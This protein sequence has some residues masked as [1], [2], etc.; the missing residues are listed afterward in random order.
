[1]NCRAVQR[2]L[3]AERDGALASHERAD[4]DAHLAQC[5][6]CRQARAA[7]AGAVESWKQSSA[8]I[9]VP[10][11]ERAWQDIRREIRTSQPEKSGSAWGL[12]R[13]ALPL[14]AAAA[15]ALAAVVSSNRNSSEPGPTRTI[16]RAQS[17]RADFVEVPTDASS[18]VYV[19]GESGWLVVWAVDDARPTRL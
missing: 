12:P 17:A 4:L 8:A 13:W 10:D 9:A 1:M 3:S 15:L 2:L 16:A 7:V 6:G 14:G 18:M 19:D 11:A 5:A